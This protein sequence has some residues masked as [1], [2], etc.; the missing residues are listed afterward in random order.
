MRWS[1]VARRGA[2]FRQGGRVAVVFLASV[3][4]VL[5]FPGVASAGTIQVPGDYPTIQAA[6]DASVDGDTIVVG[7]GTYEENIDFLGKAITVRGADGPETTVIDGGSL[8]P[9]VRFDSGEDGSSVLKGFTIRNGR[10]ATDVDDEG[11]GIKIQGSSP[12]VV[13]NVITGNRACNSGGGIAL[14][15]ASPLI[16]RNVITNNSQVGCSG[17][18]G[19]GGIGILGES[20]ALI[21]RNVISDNSWDSSGGGIALFAAGEPVIRRNIITGNSAFNTGDG[22]DIVNQSDALIVG[23]LIARNEGQGI[24]WGVPKGARGPWVVNNTIAHNQGVGVYASG[25][26]DAALLVNNI[27]VGT[28]TQP[29]LYC[30]PFYDSSP[31]ILEFNNVFSPGTD[32]YGGS[33]GDPTGTA[34]N[35][36]R[37]PWFVDPGDGDYHLRARSPS[38]DAG[39]NDAPGLPSRDI[40]GDPRIVGGVVDQGMDEFVP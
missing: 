14:L 22:I 15:A 25:F 5:A 6:I 39:T 24:F 31:P 40:D 7:P 36:S 27:L 37:R 12:K 38:I 4:A 34:G 30:D 21:V 33:C 10:A 16:K 13:G 28:S 35:I 9:V 26:D 23:N 20:Q 11:G 19:G 29:A 3:V 1:P 8:G 32:A 2:R 17:G 18:V